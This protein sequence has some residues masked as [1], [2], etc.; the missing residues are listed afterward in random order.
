MHPN[1]WKNLKK[2]ENNIH[3]QRLRYE[4]IRLD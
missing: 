1:T 2:K 3:I 4:N